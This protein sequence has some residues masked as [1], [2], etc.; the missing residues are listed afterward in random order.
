VGAVDPSAPTG[1]SVHD[2]H[3]EPERPLGARPTAA[4]VAD[5]QK[6]PTGGA[7]KIAL[8][9]PSFGPKPAWARR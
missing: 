8:P 9:P 2:P 7:P 4:D 6:A 3:E 5:D 1:G